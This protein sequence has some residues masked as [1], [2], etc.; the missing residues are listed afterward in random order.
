MC[1]DQ[2]EL[3]PIRQG[4]TEGQG[5]L[6]RRAKPPPSRGVGRG[7]RK[8][9]GLGPPTRNPASIM[10]TLKIPP[11]Y[12]FGNV[13]SLHVEKVLFPPFAQIPLPSQ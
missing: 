11:S 5:V 4:P 9:M 8:E 12:H 7:R 13:L 6:G 1:S 10:L 3:R 2:A